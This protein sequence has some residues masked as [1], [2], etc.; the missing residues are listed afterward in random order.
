M[1]VNQAASLLLVM[2]L[3]VSVGGLQKQGLDLLW[4]SVICSITGTLL[5]TVADYLD[6]S[7]SQY[8]KYESGTR[9]PKLTIMLKLSNVYHAPIEHILYNEP[10]QN[11]VP[12]F[13][14][15]R[16][17]PLK[18]ITNMNKI[19]INLHEMHQLDK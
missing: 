17:I 7:Q 14:A 16:H 13:K 2:L 4:C 12:L 10:I 19:L 9:T 6:I 8:A 15:N 18:T 11:D 3:F 5:V 1:N